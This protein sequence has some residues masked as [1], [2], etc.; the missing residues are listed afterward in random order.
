MN[1]F[2]RINLITRF[3]CSVCGTQLSLSYDKPNK[4]GEYTQDG[5]TGSDKLEQNIYIEPCEI[6][7]GVPAKQLATLKRI[8]NA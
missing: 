5:F 4:S 8:L 3:K 1:N 6:C 7:V 2:G